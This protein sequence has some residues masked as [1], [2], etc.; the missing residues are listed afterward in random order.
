ML[1]SGVF[2][3][4]LY[5]SLP[6]LSC[7]SLF[8]NAINNLYLVAWLIGFSSLPLQFS[9]LSPCQAT[10]PGASNYRSRPFINKNIS[11]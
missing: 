1:R 6:M 9:S 8:G 5:C 3:F 7:M 11:V 2:H 4:V 10:W